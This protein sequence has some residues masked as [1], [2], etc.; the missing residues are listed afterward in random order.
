MRRSM[1]YVVVSSADWGSDFP[2]LRRGL[3]FESEQ[4]YHF[5]QC[6]QR[7]LPNSSF[8]GNGSGYSFLPEKERNGSFEVARI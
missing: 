1:G 7:S 2:F 3:G 4:F 6:L 8:P 5:F